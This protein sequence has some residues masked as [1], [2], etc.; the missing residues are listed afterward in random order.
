MNE[1]SVPII[2]HFFNSNTEESK[3]HTSIPQF[4][5]GVTVFA[6]VVYIPVVLWP[7]K[8]RMLCASQNATNSNFPIDCWECFDN[9]PLSPDFAPTDFHFR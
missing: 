6:V 4:P 2:H 7:K 9:P 8:R 1:I 3:A 5:S